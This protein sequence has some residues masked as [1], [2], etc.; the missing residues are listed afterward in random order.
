MAE[1]TIIEN[2]NYGLPPY[3]EEQLTR[4]FFNLPEDAQIRL[5]ELLQALDYKF[6]QKEISIFMYDVTLLTI[7]NIANSDKEDYRFTAATIG[8]FL[9]EFGHKEVSNAN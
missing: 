8:E 2:I 9:N 3:A 5:V 1:G 4:V 6:L 7:I